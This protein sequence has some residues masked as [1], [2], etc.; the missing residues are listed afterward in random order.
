MAGN[1]TSG[2]ARLALGVDSSTSRSGRLELCLNNAWGTV[3]NRSFDNGD[4]AVACSQVVGF[5][6]DGTNLTF[7]AKSCI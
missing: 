5:K 1:C 6:R 3:C 7:E 4:A 2:E